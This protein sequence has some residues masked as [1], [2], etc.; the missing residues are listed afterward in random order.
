MATKR[1]DAL[2]AAVSKEMEGR[3]LPPKRADNRTTEGLQE[4]HKRPTMYPV[5]IRIPRADVDA[6]E[7]LAE[8]EGTT[9]SALIRKAVKELLRRAG[10]GLR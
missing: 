2:K 9:P 4:T 10:A 1:S 5:R 8:A 3:D 6:L 7:T